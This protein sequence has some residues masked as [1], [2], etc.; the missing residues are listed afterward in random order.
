[1]QRYILLNGAAG[2]SVGRHRVMSSGEGVWHAPA[3]KYP[4]LRFDLDAIDDN[5]SVPRR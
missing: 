4:Y 5:V 1:M 2:P 3:G